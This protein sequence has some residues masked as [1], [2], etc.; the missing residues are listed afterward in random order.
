MMGSFAGCSELKQAVM[1][2]VKLITSHAF[3]GDKLL[4]CIV[5]GSNF[6]ALPD[7]F[8]GCPLTGCPGSVTGIPSERPTGS[9]LLFSAAPSISQSSLPTKAPSES[10]FLCSSCAACEG[11]SDIRV[12]LTSNS[13]VD[14]AFQG[15]SN[16][17]YV[18]ISS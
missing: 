3:A 9:P 17:R 10:Y 16:L 11:Q 8:I 15:C 4:D 12:P 1:P 6:T 2:S 13:I 7:A 14:A 18:I 5:T